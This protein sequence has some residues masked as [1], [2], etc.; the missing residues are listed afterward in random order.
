[1]SENSREEYLSKKH[2][3]TKYD[4]PF[5]EENLWDRKIVHETKYWIVLK[6]DHPYFNGY[7]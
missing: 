7:T 4:C 2:Y 5:C 3:F 6:N 1:M